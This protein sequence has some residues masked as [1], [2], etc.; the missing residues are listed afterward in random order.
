[1]K[2]KEY[3]YEETNI[4]LNIKIDEHEFFDDKG[5]VAY[6]YK[7]LVEAVKNP[8]IFIIPHGYR[9][10]FI[11]ELMFQEYLHFQDITLDFEM[12]KQINEFVGNFKNLLNIEE[13]FM[14]SELGL[15]QIENQVI[16]T[17]DLSDFCGWYGVTNYSIYPLLR[18][19]KKYKLNTL[20]T[21]KNITMIISN[22]QRINMRY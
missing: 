6:S 15:S 10:A 19:I 9:L 16:S 21:K 11:Y 13:R 2:Y 14:E 22:E 1:M 18:E 7:C 17:K 3:F 12:V 20:L 8:D 4:K 5:E